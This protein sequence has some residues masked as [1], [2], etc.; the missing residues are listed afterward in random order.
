MVAGVGLD[1]GIGGLWRDGEVER[2]GSSEGES[3]VG[4]GWDWCPASLLIRVLVSLSCLGRV[5][6]EGGEPSELVLQG[7]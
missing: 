5:R 2:E 3:E 1:V 7:L 6:K 4:G